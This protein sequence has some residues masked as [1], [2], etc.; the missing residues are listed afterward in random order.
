MI[1][2]SMQITFG[3]STEAAYV[4]QSGDTVSAFQNDLTL[5]RAIAEHDMAPAH[6]EAIAGLNGVGWSLWRRRARRVQGRTC[7]G[8]A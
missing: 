8:D 6:D 4:N 5:M 1:G 3:S 7:T 2:D